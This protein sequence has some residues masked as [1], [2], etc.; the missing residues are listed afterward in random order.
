[1]ADQNHP[2]GKANPN[3]F[4]DITDLIPAAKKERRIPHQNANTDLTEIVFGQGETKPEPSREDESAGQIPVRSS[5][6][7]PKNEQ[8]SF[9]VKRYIPPHTAKEEM[10]PPKPDDIYRPTDS[11]IHEVRIFQWKS[12]F[13]YY[14]DFCT[15]AKKLYHVSGRPCTHVPFFSY[16]PQYTQLNREQMNWYLFWRD[17]VRK[18]I[19]PDTDYSYVLLYAF[20]IINLSDIMDH[21]FG[22]AQLYA[23]CQAYGKQNPR[24]LSYLNEWICD[25]SLIH[26]L[27]PIFTNDFSM[28]ESCALKEFF[29]PDNSDKDTVFASALITF[30]SNYHYQ[31]SKFATKD[32]IALYDEHM[33]GAV[34]SCIRDKG[35]VGQKMASAKKEESRLI[36]DAFVF[37]PCATRM[38]R[39]LEIDYCSLSR[40]HEL[41]IL[42]TD[43]MKYT[44]N[45]LRAYLG[46]KS[47][48]SLFG[49]SAEFRACIDRY[50]ELSLPAVSRIKAVKIEE[51]APYEKLYDQPCT[52]FSPRHAEQIE[53]ESWNTTAALIDAF[54]D[55]PKSNEPEHF[56]QEAPNKI[57]EIPAK[58]NDSLDFK[59]QK[60]HQKNS[61]PSGTT[62]DTVDTADAAEVGSD[63][64][65]VQR[66]AE[67]LGHLYP[68][69]RLA[70]QCDYAGQK[71]F[72][73]HAGLM[74][75][76]V[77]DTINE[78]AA[79][80]LGDIIL[81]ENEEGYT[82]MEDYIGYWA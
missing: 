23:L 27:P 66:L 67:R 73:R 39:K 70:I 54:C 62:A 22:Q 74:S 59:P 35:T 13:R 8:D 10:D 42:I 15:L 38:K 49:L 31:K 25:Y 65:E 57:A 75:E 28:V 64:P 80:I 77:A 29:I 68:F 58:E 46:V 18:G 3:D 26:H 82:I 19:F 1:M 63:L 41:R 76:S 34:L 55:P 4:W 11:L 81:E 45:K 72:C 9:V 36:R 60:P 47:R 48:L 6:Q 32:N 79:D 37:A 20:E 69:I 50:F 44:E 56:E 52:A 17:Q 53:K 78:A 5:V 7:T 24:I 33:L 12:N 14:E 21:G 71:E 2:S 51:R 43:I 16:V 40:S 30:C 61:T